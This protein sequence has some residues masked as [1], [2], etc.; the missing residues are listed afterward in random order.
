MRSPRLLMAITVIVALGAAACGG[1]DGADG[2]DSLSTGGG[3]D[4]GERTVEIDMVDIAFEPDALQVEKGETVRFVFTNTGE[5]DHDAFIGDR[6]AQAEHEAEMREDE[7]AGHGGGHGDED[8]EE[9]VT[10]EPGDSGELTHTFDDSGPIE[11][12]CHQPGHYEGG[13]RIEVEVA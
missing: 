11:I 12:G 2:A 7:E 8:S 5:I 9:A 13:M 6:K 1:D 4:D 10:V 3:N